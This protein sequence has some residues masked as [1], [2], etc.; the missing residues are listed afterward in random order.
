MI[1]GLL[2]L[3][4]VYNERK[5]SFIPEASIV[6]VKQLLIVEPTSQAA[7]KTGKQ[8]EAQP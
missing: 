4:F 1:A 6:N 8:E 3:T 5:F 7:R 2:K